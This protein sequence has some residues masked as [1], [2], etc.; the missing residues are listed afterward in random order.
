[1][2]MIKSSCDMWSNK[3][4][5][6]KLWSHGAVSYSLFLRWDQQQDTNSGFGETI[7]SGLVQLTLSLS[8]KT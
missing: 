1:M 7:M 2:H 4:N 5:S 8:L 3:S 6:T